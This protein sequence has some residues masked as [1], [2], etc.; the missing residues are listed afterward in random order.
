MTVDN[1]TLGK[2]FSE[3]ENEFQQDSDITITPVAGDPP[4]EYE[5]T[6]HIPCTTKDEQGNIEIT[7]EHVVSMSIPFGFPH[8]PPSCKPKSSIFHPD[9][10][11]SAVC[12]GDFWSNTPS[13]VELIRHLK[14]MIG[15][16]RYSTQN[17]FNPAA[18]DWFLA[19]QSQLPFAKE[20][21]GDLKQ[22]PPLELEKTKQEFDVVQDSDFADDFTFEEE[23]LEYNP[24]DQSNIS[25][26]VPV[27]QSVPKDMAP[28]PYI[29]SDIDLQ[30][31]NLLASKRHFQELDAELSALPDTADSKEIRQL[32]KIASTAMEKG[33]ALH[34]QALQ[35]QQQDEPSKA[36]ECFQAVEKHVA[37][38]PNILEKISKIEHLLENETTEPDDFSDLQT[39]FAV[40]APV[41]Q[42][43]ES[44][45][46][47]KKNAPPVTKQA[48]VLEHKKGRKGKLAV[49]K[50]S[51]PLVYSLAGLVVIAGSGLGFL[52]INGSSKLEQSR[53]F[54]QQCTTAVKNQQFRTAQN[55]CLD[56]RKAS[57]SIILFHQA[58][59]AALQ[60]Q[61]HSALNSQTLQQGLKGKVLFEGE[62]VLKATVSQ[63]QELIQVLA[64]GET[65][66][67]ESDWL[68]AETNLRRAIE[69]DDD[70]KVL[71]DEELTRLSRQA[72]HAAFIAKLEAIENAFLQ[73][74]DSV[75][76]AALNSLSDELSSL[77]AASAAPLRS[78]VEVILAKYQF[79]SLKKQAD[80]LF[81]QS[82]WPGAMS[83]FAKAAETGKL[84]SETEPPELTDIRKNITRAELYSNIDAGNSL[85]ADG[86]WDDAISHYQQAIAILKSSYQLLNQGDYQHSVEKLERIILQS[87]IIRDRQA[88]ETLRGEGKFNEALDKLAVVMASIT[89]SAYADEAEFSE[90]LTDARDT[91]QELKRKALLDY[92]TTYLVENYY[93]FVTR[94]YVAASKDTIS[95]PS[96]E[97]VKELDPSHYLFKLECTESGR[98]RPLKLV[99]YYS[100]DLDQDKWE[101]ANADSSQ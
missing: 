69:L 73:G 43:V 59:V 61:I 97:F 57:D 38:F 62:Y 100:Y 86:R 20:Y 89:G 21:A 10:D 5:I 39:D 7:S 65:A 96:A 22:P 82:D 26:S 35:L 67:S 77:P 36:L 87:T 2:L 3:I 78:R 30:R 83:L 64:S 54:L 48:S 25:Q 19:N 16:E 94:N 9:F 79:S 17:P 42:K 66:F 1:Q 99:M 72:A 53:S 85:F 47:R 45:P 29:L 88:V 12:L 56:S 11:N 90:I 37:D 4:N 55:A 40:D 14:M 27:E 68:A 49:P 24:P 80:T 15:G 51:R 75:D 8:F 32:R 93:S 28:R 52:A 50:F 81:S 98:G 101:F 6:F 74:N 18:A 84:L 31:F 71:P 70:L 60:Q 76:L 58:E 91:S 46:T 13:L 95:S 63:R 92:C 34:Q 23:T 41:A 44:T 33:S